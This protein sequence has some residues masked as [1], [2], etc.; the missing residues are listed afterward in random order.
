MLYA[1]AGQN[2]DNALI[3]NALTLACEDINPQPA[4]LIFGN[5]LKNFEGKLLSK[6]ICFWRGFSLIHVGGLYAGKQRLARRTH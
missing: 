6:T 5:T 3:H 2:P 4:G 1:N